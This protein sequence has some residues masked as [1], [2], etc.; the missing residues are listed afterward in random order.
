MP[1]LKPGTL[2]PTRLDDEAIAAA[3]F[4]DPNAQPLSKE[5][6]AQVRPT[7]RGRPAGSGSKVQI[8]IRFDED[9][10]K[11]FKNNGEGWQSRM[12]EALREWLDHH[13]VSPVSEGGAKA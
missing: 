11:A 7:R 3:S 8:T 10:V 9:I 1:K 4:G 2:I 12:N 6:L 13:D 5:E